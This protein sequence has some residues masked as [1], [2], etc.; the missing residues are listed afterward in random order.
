MA[1]LSVNEDFDLGDFER[2]AL[3]LP[4]YARP[5][6]VRLRKGEGAQTTSTFK[7]K[8]RAWAAEGYDPKAIADPLYLYDRVADHYVSLDAELFARL[9][10]G[11]IPL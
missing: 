11:E 7:T 5:V 9:T 2:H 8:G 4:T 1:L 3:A 10:R 6:F